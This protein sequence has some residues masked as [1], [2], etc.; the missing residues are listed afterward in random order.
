MAPK[1]L[2]VLTNVGKIEASGQSIGWYLVSM[3]ICSTLLLWL[4]FFEEKKR[5]R[6]PLAKFTG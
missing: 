1:I 2:V 3:D 6:N 5:K 4:Q